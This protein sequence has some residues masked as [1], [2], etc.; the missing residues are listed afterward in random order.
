MIKQRLIEGF[1]RSTKGKN[2]REANLILKNDLISNFNYKDEEGEILLDSTVISED[3]YNQYSCKININRENCE[4]TYVHCSCHDFE[5]KN[6]ELYCCKHL[7]A[8]FYNFIDL[9]DKDPLIKEELA[10]E[11]NKEEVKSQDEKGI[12][13]YLLGSTAYKEE[14][15]FEVILNKISWSGKIAAEF[16]IGLSNMKSAKMYTLKDIDGFLVAYYNNIPIKYGKDFTFNIKEQK[17]GIKDKK[18]LKFIELLKEIDLSSGGFKRAS[19]KLVSG[20]QIVIP[21]GLLREFMT[22][23]KNHRVYLGSGFYSRQIE[24][25][26]IE[27]YIPIPM[28][29]KKLGDI[30]KLEA[31]SGL[32]ESLTDNDDVFLYNTNIYLPLEEQLEALLPYLEVFSHG[33][34]LFFS[35]DQEDK[36]LRELIPNMQRVTKDIELSSNLR[37]KIVISPVKF[38]FYFD[39]DKEIY[40]TFKV[41]YDKYEFNYFDNIEEKIIYRDA[42]KEEEVLSLLR[43]LGFERVNNV[44]LF[45]RDEEYVFRFFKKDIAKLQEIGEVFY[46]D[47]FNGIKN[48]TKGDFKATIKKGKFDYFKIDFSLGDISMEETANILRAFRDNKKFYKLNTGEF[49]DLEEI[50]LNNFLK[51]LD[52]L[53]EE[54]EATNSIEFSK[55]KGIYVE[56][57]LEENNLDYVRG[58]SNVKS[59]RQ[60]LKKLKAKEEFKLPENLKATLREYQVEGYRWLKT[61][62]YL[63]FGGILGDEMG[64]GKTLQTIAFLS[65]FEKERTSLVVAPTS[66]LYNW[67]NE[68][69]KFAPHMKIALLNGNLEE[70]LNYLKEYDNYDVILTTYNLLK[71]DISYYKDLEF[72]YCI[73][74][75]AQNIKNAHSLTAKAVKSIKSR[76]HL[77]L[78]GTP[79]ENSLMELW[80]I[81]DF[82]MPG[83]L[84]DEKGFSTRYHRRLEEDKVILDDLNRFIRPFILRRY[85]KD[86]IKELPSKIE[87]TLII[88]LEEEQKKVYGTYAN[89]AKELVEKKVKDDEFKS[90]KIEILSYITKLR[91]LAL[92]PSVV[93]EDY[94]G[95]SGKINALIDILKDAI[96]GGHKILV[97]S[98]FTAVLKNI[99]RECDFNNINYCYLDG[100]IPSKERGNIIEKFNKDSSISVF[101]ISLKAG[102]TGLNLTSAD[103]VIHFDPWWNPAVEDQA[104]DRAHRIGQ[105][106]VVEVI[107]LIAEET[108]EER[109]LD[110]QKQKRELISKVV[111]EERDLGENIKNLEEE[112]LLSLFFDV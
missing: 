54:I 89:Y 73:L 75:E 42:S 57:Y 72:N 48:L 84:Y 58:R 65:S 16:K 86:V 31:L 7:T 29:L 4:V 52:S 14:L 99:A 43:E 5:N 34:T 94:K 28:N 22:I 35:K 49:L 96:L 17:I 64:L 39:K 69:K 82:I 63:G 36:I 26:I 104:T 109:I 11:I 68:F 92:D 18:L 56:E 41:C 112:D 101:L 110:L 13:N 53:Q 20:K 45:F 78:T 27:D 38:K 59:L 9:L 102:G 77:A 97:F 71:R 81:F 85:K 90:S 100:S 61:L 32:P 80:S 87:K 15:K 51:L 47:K 21:K 98:Q 10:L 60:S 62:D 103:I 8:T 111:G 88:P 95:E 93:M 1:N 107:K 70:R 79:I 91:Q 3:L 106:N 33:N 83:Y 24:T 6:K 108:I 40:L 25:E 74:D 76:G 30:I 37:D 19:E 67:K 23:I 55:A 66:L 44:F 105:K 50:E 46:S 12:L 2:Q